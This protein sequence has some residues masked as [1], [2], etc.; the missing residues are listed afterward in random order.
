MFLLLRWL[1]AACVA[2]A[3]LAPGPASALRIYGEEGPLICEQEPGGAGGCFADLVRAVRDEAGSDAEVQCVPWARGYMH[4]RLGPEVMLYPTT[5][6]PE[7][8]DQFRWVGPVARVRWAF[9]GLP[10][11]PAVRSLDE[12]RKVGRIGTYFDDV[13]E[14]FLKDKGFTNLESSRSNVLNARKLA[15][16]RL[17]LLVSTN[18]GIG[19]V[20]DGAGLPPGALVLRHAFRSADIYLAFSADVPAEEVARWAAALERLRAGGGLARVYGR[21]FPGETPP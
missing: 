17:D 11:G 14:K 3:C 1:T 6:T 7:R 8:E 12:A 20:L 5:R 16:G 19:A 13:R 2:W 9:Y 10:D 18:L 4:L 21:C 15:A